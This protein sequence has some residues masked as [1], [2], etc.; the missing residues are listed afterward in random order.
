MHN[1][2]SILYN[3]QVFKL[4]QDYHGKDEAVVFA[5]SGAAGGQR[6]PVVGQRIALLHVG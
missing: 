6:F 1:L 5:R 4:L 3:E 2:Y